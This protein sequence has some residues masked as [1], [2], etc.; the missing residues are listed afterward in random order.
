MVR[1]GVGS[2]ILS[3]NHSPCV[4]CLFNKSVED[5]HIV[6]GIIRIISHCIPVPMIEYSLSPGLAFREGLGKPLS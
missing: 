4:P 2:S 6:T 3:P 5:C 1:K